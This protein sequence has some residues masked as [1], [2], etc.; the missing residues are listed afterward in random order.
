MQGFPEGPP[1]SVWGLRGHTTHGIV[2]FPPT[3]FFFPH[4]ASR[5]FFFLPWLLYFI[6]FFLSLLLL[7]LLFFSCYR[8]EWN[9]KSETKPHHANGYKHCNISI[10]HTST[11]LCTMYTTFGIPRDLFVYYYSPLVGGRGGIRPRHFVVRAAAGVQGVQAFLGI[12][13]MRGLIFFSSPLFFFFF[14][15]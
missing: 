11:V 7:F 15:V 13:Q 5:V 1:R 8:L 12:N 14:L 3:A 2:T 6:C 9:N 4:G 10:Q